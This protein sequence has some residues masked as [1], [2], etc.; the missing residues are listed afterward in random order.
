VIQFSI[1]FAGSRIMREWYGSFVPNLLWLITPNEV[2]PYF[3]I[4]SAIEQWS[5]APA[6]DRGGEGTRD[7]SC[8]SSSAIGQA[9]S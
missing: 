3:A 4:T 6:P 1:Q 2:T 8:T 7:A 5:R 9:P